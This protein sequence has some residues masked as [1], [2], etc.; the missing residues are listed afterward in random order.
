MSLV[1]NTRLKPAT[2]LELITFGVKMQISAATNIIDMYT[3]Y[4]GYWK[5]CV[6]RNTQPIDALTYRT[7]PN[8]PFESVPP[9]SELPISGWGSFMQVNSGAASPSGV[10]DFEVCNMKDALQVA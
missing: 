10:V 4:S 1:P 2:S 3:R 9:N 7:E 5:N 6:I 8:Q